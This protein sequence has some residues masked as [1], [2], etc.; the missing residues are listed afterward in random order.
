MP[1]TVACRC[2]QRFAAPNH[3]QGKQVP[4]PVCKAPISIPAA[5]I[6]IACRCGMVSFA[7]D[8]LRGQTTR[9]P[10][11][12]DLIRVPALGTDDLQVAGPKPA[13]DPLGRGPRIAPPAKS[14]WLIVGLVAGGCGL[15]VVMMIAALA[16]MALKNSLGQA[17]RPT[18]PPPG[19]STPPV[20]PGPGYSRSNPPRP[21]SPPPTPPP[22]AYQPP[23][24]PPTS[25]RPVPSNPSF[26]PFGL[27]PAPPSPPSSSPSSSAS[28]PPP[29]APKKNVTLPEGIATW[30]EQPSLKLTGIRRVGPASPPSAHFSW[31]T[32][33]LPFLDHDETF[34]KL[35]FSQPLTQ[36]ANLQVGAT[37]IPQFLNP[38]DSRQRWKGYPLDGL[39]LTHF[40][41]MSGVEDARNVV[42]AKL[43]RSDPR[44]GVFGY[45]EVARAE[46]ITDGQ[47]QTIMVVGG[48][49]LANPWLFGGGATIRGAREPLFD[50]TSGLGTKGLAGGGTLA[51]MADG[52]VRQINP[53]IDPAVFKAMC[54]I[55]GSEKVD[56]EK[57][58]TPF[59]W[60]LLKK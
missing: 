46:Q 28:S 4:C 1:V 57:S 3:L 47:S 14:P 30:Y 34:D 59:D 9:C 19:F 40:V 31:M 53:Q 12:G 35:N 26:P 21:W 58:A 49:E 7:P 55:H 41:G 10:G 8:T 18:V 52:S 32:G 37:V 45:D 42:A 6:K 29:A 22:S 17:R 23:P 24:P 13:P 27:P 39:A 20:D 56:L 44:A 51:I 38:L 2:G 50:K 60:E 5:G 16:V 11:C 36:Q 33:L 54:T 15:V 43:P 48:G 25:I